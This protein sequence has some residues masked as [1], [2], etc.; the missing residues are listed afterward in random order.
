M[1]SQVAGQIVYNLDVNTSKFVAG[2]REVDKEL[3]GLDQGFKKADKSGQ[4]FGGGINKITAALGGL[5]T[6]EGLRRL[7][8][9]S[10]EFTVLQ[11]R[12]NRFS[13]GVAAG[14][15]NYQ[16]L[17][18]ISS[19]TG[20]DMGT[21]VKTWESLTGALKEMG[22]SN[23]DI[24]MLT[25]TLM[26][27]GVV[28]GSSA[29][30]MKNGLR[31]L[32][33]SFSG[34]IIR[35]EEFNSVLE[36]T[37]EIARQ[38][39]KGLGV[40][41]SE[42][43]KMM[44][45]SKLTTDVV[46]EALKKQ[47]K[48]ID[49]DFA[50]M[51]RTVAQATNAITN[52]FGNALAKLDKESGFS[53]SLAKGIDLVAAKISGFA[54]DAQALSDA[55]DMIGGAASSFAA[56]MAGRVLMSLYGVATAQLA[57][58]KST[59]AMVGPQAS[60]AASALALAR[61]EFD[62]ALATSTAATAR[63]KAAVGMPTY[64]GL[65]NAAAIAEERTTLA[66]MQLSAAMTTSAASVTLASAA[67]SGLKTA[68]AFLGGPAGVILLA[69][70]AMYEFAKASRETKVDVDQLRGSLDKLTFSQLAK[71]SN[72]AGDDITKLNKRLSASMS[73]LRTQTQKPWESDGDFSKRKTEMQAEFDGIQNEINARREL[74]TAIKAQQDQLSKD[75]INSGSGG[76]SEPKH[77]TSDADQKVIDSLKE[78]RALA[79]LAGE[80]RARLAA[81]QKLSTTATAEEKQ[82][83]GD[84]A[85]EIYRLENAKKS[86]SKASKDAAKEQKKDDAE[87]KK[88]TEENTKA[89]TDYAVS[90]GMAAMK[91]EDL[92]RAQAAAK[93]NKFATP[94]DV[95]TMDALAK[96]MYRVQQAEE[97]R[98]LLGSVDPIQG[99]NQAHVK[100]LA[101]LELL[102]QQKLLSNERYLELKSLAEDAHSKNLVAIREQEFR[103][104]SAGNEVMMASLDALG[105]SG[106]Q[107]ISGILSGTMSLQDAMQGIANTVFNTVIGSFTEMGIE[108]VK[109][110]IIKRSATKATEAAQVAG[111]AAVGS[112]Q[113]GTTAAIASTTTGAAATTGAAVA[114]SMAPAAGLSSIASFGGAAVIGGAALL[115]TMLLAKSFGGGRQYGGDVNS[116]SMYRINETGP[117]ILTANDGK[118]YLTGAD[119]NITSNKDAFGGGG[120]GSNVEI[121]IINNTGAQVTQTS[122]Q[123]DR[124]QVIEIV[125]GDMMEGGP[126]SQATN[127]ITGTQRPG[128]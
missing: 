73:E 71:A 127:N 109:Q 98:K 124:K 63:A 88:N 99:A 82:K 114:T 110:E 103:A 121:T 34:G 126:I 107:A 11:A 9:L 61:A 102:N 58:I 10:E 14:A 120:G 67:M 96:A 17:L 47:V 94:E 59:M 93:L 97:N 128:S 89:I 16:R 117:E 36:N 68:M 46:F 51:P 57:A 100:E 41:F 30:E 60:A 5:A 3:A 101:D 33:Q 49:R 6:I 125:V 38:L 19:K 22:K 87:A 29:E 118:Q 74:Q 79:D 23:D 115:G 55:L 64:V 78:Q 39:A 92:A 77:K 20:S 66:A 45:D 90:I 106:A 53:A 116:G 7:Q 52:E 85:V 75:Q 2:M 84:L 95:A 72:D 105:A 26:K 86:E 56:I 44:L 27:M 65:L 32:G 113:V 25:D 54:G 76:S 70:Y 12:I 108:W 119:G 80:A 81:E 28:G 50:N 15:D 35:G 83:V 62:A 21:A 104:M 24:I 123:L 31:Q 8:A 13:G 112:A 40:P 37:P 4:A 48:E 43:R 91:G 42:L 69:V 122:K 18:T 111:I 1:T